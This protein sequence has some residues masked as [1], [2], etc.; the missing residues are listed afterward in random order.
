[1]M[2]NKTPFGDLFFSDK[3]R[4]YLKE[5]RYP[6]ERNSK[7][8]FT[9]GG[10]YRSG[11]GFSFPQQL[12]LLVSGNYSVRNI[13]IHPVLSAC[14]RLTAVPL[15]SIRIGKARKKEESDL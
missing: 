12:Y 6:E 9:Q 10:L 5:A 7:K 13:N 3:S 11:I 1:M 14:H 15:G 8:P 2:I 4:V